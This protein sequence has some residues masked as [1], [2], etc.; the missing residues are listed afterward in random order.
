M[1]VAGVSDPDGCVTTVADESRVTGRLS[2]RGVG[3]TSANHCGHLKAV[4]VD[5]AEGRRAQE[6]FVEGI[7]PAQDFLRWRATR[8]TNQR[9]DAEDLVQDTLLKA[10]ASFETYCAGTN[11][12]AWLSRIMVNAW[13]D[14]YRS[15]QRRPRERL[16]AEV[17][18][19]ELTAGESG[20]SG[21]GAA[22]SAEM[23]ALQSMPSDAELALAALPDDVRKAVFYADIAGFRNTEIAVILAIP[24]GT[25]GSRLHR[26][27]VQLRQALSN[28][29]E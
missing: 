13:V 4:G 20:V 22:S 5:A 11:L 23:H 7:A 18:D 2:P 27:R 19:H 28:T 9:A 14:K 16:S 21:E 3:P 6:R 8:L 15:S 26:G 25:V 12:K 10:Y 17:T 24:V 1:C 29:E